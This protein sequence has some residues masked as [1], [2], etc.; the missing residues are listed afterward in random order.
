M[1][2]D[3]EHVMGGEHSHPHTHTHEHSRTPLEELT[4]LMKYMVG[5]NAAHA[6]ELADLAGQ[7]K[8]A[9]KEE[10]YEKI[11]VAVAEFDKGNEILASVLKEMDAGK[12]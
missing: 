6:K 8:D 5:H 4:A 10:A 9:G 12:M 1:H 7:L 11:M 3:H 2:I